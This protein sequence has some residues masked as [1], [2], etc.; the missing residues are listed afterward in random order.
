[1]LAQIFGKSSRLDVYVGGKRIKV[2][3]QASVGKGGEAD[4]FD[5]GNGTVLKLW[6]TPEHPDYEGAPG[7]QDAA[8]ERIDTHQQKLRAF[9]SGLPARVIV[10][11]ALATDRSG[12][13]ISGYTMGFVDGAEVLMCFGDPRLRDLAASS[14]RALVD[15]HGTVAGLHA[16]GVVIGDF[17]DLNVLVKDEQAYLI[18]A[19][20]FQFGSFRCRV[21]TERFVDPLHCDPLEKRPLLCKP[22]SADSDWCAFTVMVMQTL[23]SV[24]PYGGIYKPKSASARMPECARP[25]RR[26]TVFHPE[27]LYPKPAAPYAVLPDDLLQHLHLVFE[28]DQRGA[29]PRALLDGLGWT[30]C[31]ACCAGHARAVCPFCVTTAPAA[32]KEITVVRGEVTATRIFATR[33]VILAAALEDGEL[34]YLIHEDNEYRREDGSVVLSG[35]LDLLARF[36]VRGDKTLLARGARVI[37]LALGAVIDRLEVDRVGMRPVFAVNA[38]HRYWVRGGR[39]FRSAE[40]TRE[41]SI[42]Q[43][44]SYPLPM[45]EVLAGQT[46]IWAGDRFGF[47]FYRAG[48]LS[49]AFVF[50]AKS[51][52]IKDTVKLPFLGGQ[53][54]DA[55][56]IVGDSHAWVLLA[57][58]DKGRT[59]HQC[60]V[61]GR[62]GEVVATAEGD[63][64][65]GTWLGT[66]RGK[67]AVGC[68]L[69]A[70][71]DSGLSRVEARQGTLVETRQFPDT[72]PFVS[73]ASTLFAGPKALYVVSANT[74]H[75]LRIRA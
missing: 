45:G 31:P 30:R 50:D 20:S 55:T 29:F 15:L 35:P 10:P 2:S 17:N 21:F 65:D 43:A 27:V 13:R 14:A 33:G 28:K 4:V 67:C 34:R 53:L 63:A 66:L 70:A 44:W 57:A 47:G 22:F 62:D 73:R 74:I 61:V 51:P 5:I 18:D 3:P 38:H 68:F 6:K 19:D 42:E 75:T 40:G 12:N 72:E 41:V 32:V 52:G 59:R 9:P 11:L 16:R 54:V 26:I 8:R 46:R 24:G 60:V 39:L 64:D 36:A 37:T 7:E 48:N 71:T 69:L 1:M 49:V 23:L 25:L 56:C 58:N